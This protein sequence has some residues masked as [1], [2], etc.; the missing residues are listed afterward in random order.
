MLATVPAET[1]REKC[2]LGHED[3]VEPAGDYYAISSVLL[4]EAGREATVALK[5]YGIP[6]FS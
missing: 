1:W 2:K 3:P 6:T 4:A 5:D